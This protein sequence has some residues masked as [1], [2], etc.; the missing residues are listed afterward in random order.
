VTALLAVGAAIGVTHLGGT[1]SNSASATQAQGQSQSESQAT[2]TGGANGFRSGRGTRGTITGVDG[3]TITVDATD[4]NGGSSTVE[5]TT[6]SDTRV[7]EAVAGTVSDIAVGDTVMVEGSTSGTS[8][9]ATAIRDVGDQAIGAGAMGA[10][11]PDDGSAP[12]GAPGGGE[13]PNGGQAP[14]GDQSGQV[15]PNG[16][17]GGGQGTFGTVTAVDGSTI[18]IEMQDGTTMTVSTASDT[19][20]TVTREISVADLVTGDTISVTGTTSGSTVAATSI[21]RGEIG[22]GFGAPPGG[23]T[24]AANAD[25]TS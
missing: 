12:T 3:S 2:A 24:A 1:S 20:V 23:A 6:D 10:Q 8:I 17:P 25:P 22:G 11:P 4:A 9:A 7:T 5:V 15:P 21:R 16:R 14:S 13:M 18:T 19:T